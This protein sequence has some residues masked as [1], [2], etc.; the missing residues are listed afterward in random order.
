MLRITEYVKPSTIW[1]NAKDYTDFGPI[2][3]LLRGYN[4]EVTKIDGTTH[5]MT[6]NW[7][8]AS[9]PEEFF[10]SK[11]NRRFR[12]DMDLVP[13]GRVSFRG[14]SQEYWD[15]EDNDMYI[16]RLSDEEV[17]KML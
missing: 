13:T 7:T 3:G 14:Y 16:N 15:Y 17:K 8:Y 9:N 5:W 6:A 11:C 4:L 12:E 1:P 2:A 10:N